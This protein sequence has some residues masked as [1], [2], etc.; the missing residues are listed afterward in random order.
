MFFHLFGT[1]IECVTVGDGCEVFQD[2]KAVVNEMGDAEG[3]LSNSSYLRTAARRLLTRGM[4]PTE[5]GWSGWLGRYQAAL[6]KATAEIEESK[7]P[8][9]VR[10]QRGNRS[11]NRSFGR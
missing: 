7:E 4:M 5:D 11:R 9:M 2:L 1:R 6:S 8:D 3:L 10:G